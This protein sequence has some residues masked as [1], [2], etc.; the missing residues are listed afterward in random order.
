MSSAIPF[1]ALP[2]KFAVAGQ[3]TASLALFARETCLMSH[4][5]GS[6]N[7]SVTTLL[8]VRLLKVSSETNFVALGVIITRTSKPALFSRLASSVDLAAAIPPVTPMIIV[9]FDKSS[10]IW[11]GAFLRVLCRLVGRLIEIVQHFYLLVRRV[12][13][14]LARR[15]RVGYQVFGD[16]P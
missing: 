13:Y 3:I 1:A 5:S 7:M 14:I 15:W 12:R 8:P 10:V 16:F 4:S 11:L 6:S 9:G 2:M